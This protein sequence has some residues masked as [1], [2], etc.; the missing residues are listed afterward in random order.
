MPGSK[1]KSNWGHTLSLKYAPPVLGS[2]TLILGLY[3][4]VESADN[5]PDSI[6]AYLIP[7]VLSFYFLGLWMYVYGRLVRLE[8]RDGGFVLDDSR[9]EEFVKWDQVEAIKIIPFFTPPLYKMRLKD[10]EKA[11][12]FVTGKTYVSVFFFSLDYSEMGKLIKAKKR[13]NNW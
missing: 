3:N 11:V 12:L 2:V 1:L 6:Y 7:L 4:Y 9:E 8:I 10:R 13:Q 5:D